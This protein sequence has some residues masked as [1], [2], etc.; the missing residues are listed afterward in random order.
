MNVSKLLDALAKGPGGVQINMTEG[1]VVTVSTRY[2]PSVTGRGCTIEEAAIKVAKVLS[3][4]RRPCPIIQQA[5]REYEE[6]MT[7]LIGRP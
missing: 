1:C 5:V 2:H 3:L 7:L 4:R 6:H